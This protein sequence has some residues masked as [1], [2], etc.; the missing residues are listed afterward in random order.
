MQSSEVL[1]NPGTLL[2]AGFGLVLILTSGV[3][4]TGLNAIN[5]MLGRAALMS[6]LAAI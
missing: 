2:F 6:D 1:R 5:G 4:V 3:A